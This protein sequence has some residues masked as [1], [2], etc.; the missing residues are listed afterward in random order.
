MKY[1]TFYKTS[2]KVACVCKNNR[3][4]FKRAYNDLAI[5]YHQHSTIVVTE[6]LHSQWIKSY[7]KLEFNAIK[8]HIYT[9]SYT[10]SHQN[11]KAE[12][13][14]TSSS[15]QSDHLCL[16]PSDPS[17]RADRTPSSP[18]FSS[19]PAAAVSSHRWYL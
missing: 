1:N 4:E 12:N 6:A 19:S 11:G 5:L 15:R 13:Q 14:L 3:V 7:N 2:I 10:K 8:Q 16:S 17:G 9:F 18:A